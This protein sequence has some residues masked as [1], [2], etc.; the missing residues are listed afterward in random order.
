MKELLISLDSQSRKPLYEQ[1]YSFVKAEIRQGKIQSGERLPSSRALAGQ[2]SVSRSTIDLDYEQLL[3]EGFLQ[4]IPCKG[5]FVSDVTELYQLGGLEPSPEP[6]RKKVSQSYRYDFA[7]NGIDRDGFPLNAWRK[8]SKAVLAGGDDSLFQMG[9]PQGEWEL[10]EAIASYLH[11]A[12]GV[13]CGPEQIITGAGNDFLLMLL[14]VLLGRDKAIAMENPTYKSAYQCF[15]SLGH[16]VRAVSLDESGMRLDELIRSRAQIA[17]VMPSHQ[18]P[19]GT[20]MP[21]GR[22][23]QLLS[24]AAAAEGRFLIEDDYDSEFRYK[25]KPI[26]ALQGY[27]TND[28]VIY[29]GTFSKSMAPAIR[30]SYMVLPKSLMNAYEERGRCFSAT[31]SRMDQKILGTFLREGYFERHLNRMRAVYKNK[32][33]LLLKQLRLLSNIFT[34]MGENAGVHVLVHFTGGMNE[35][36]AVEKA[37][38]EGIRVYG[39]SEYFIEETEAEESHTVLLGY[40]SLEEEEIKNACAGLL[41]AWGIK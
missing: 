5:Y 12:R 36:E 20:I 27:D 14:S 11:H 25:G 38:A 33:D 4:S 26:P 40:A 32:H 18:F 28:R 8:I 23:L 16:D 35:K 39:L 6:V 9:D 34:V 17:Y 29:L 24:W 31:V 7:V 37:A 41:R 22:R 3:S 15:K 2:L 10:R 1:I 30:I 19:M 13:N 21:I